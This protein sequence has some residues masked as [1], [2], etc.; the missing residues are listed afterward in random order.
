M[1]QKKL[2]AGAGGRWGAYRDD[3]V[4]GGEK[5]GRLRFI[6]GIGPARAVQQLLGRPRCPPRGVVALVR[7]PQERA[8][9]AGVDPQELIGEQMFPK[10]IELLTRKGVPPYC[11]DYIDSPERLNERALPPIEYFRN[12]LS[13]SDC[14]HAD[15][16]HAVKVWESFKCHTLR[17]YHIPAD[18]CPAVDRCP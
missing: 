11:Y 14:D 5:A 8:G 1:L 6:S 17:D 4:V 12:E 16:A 13:E 3:A 18:R 2:T 7:H 9:V 15:Y 10:Q